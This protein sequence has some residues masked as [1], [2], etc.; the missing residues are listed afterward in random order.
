MKHPVT[1][2]MVGMFFGVVCQQQLSHVIRRA[3]NVRGGAL[4][5]WT[6]LGGVLAD[7]VSGWM[8][9]KVGNRF[10][11]GVA[12]GFDL[13]ALTGALRAVGTDIHFVG[14]TPWGGDGQLETN[15]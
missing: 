4:L 2:I 6:D 3:L 7:W 13:A 8:T 5:E 12:E 14:R 1:E 10:D 11:D 15:R 9:T